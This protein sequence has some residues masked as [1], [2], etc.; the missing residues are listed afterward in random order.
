MKSAFCKTNWRRNKNELERYKIYSDFLDKVVNDDKDNK[1]F[2]DI[3]SL[4]N[5]FFNL[6]KEHKK[7]VDRQNE[8][9]TQITETKANEKIVMSELQN[10]LYKMQKKMQL[11]QKDLENISNQNSKLEQEFE[12]EITK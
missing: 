9:N 6:R 7:L 3:D 5:R 10:E 1:E 8:I 11:Y 2:E 4:K 12:N